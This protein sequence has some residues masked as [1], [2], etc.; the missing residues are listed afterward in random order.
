MK[1]YVIV[2]TTYEIPY[3]NASRDFCIFDCLEQVDNFINHKTAHND[4]DDSCSLNEKHGE[5]V[6]RIYCIVADGPIDA[7]NR[8]YKLQ[9]R[10]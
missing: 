8:A 7:R 6:N 4:L 10:N 2:T 9:W 5:K 1:T 3:Y